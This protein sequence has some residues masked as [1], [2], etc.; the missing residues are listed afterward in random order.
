LLEAAKTGIA[1]FAQALFRGI[2]DI[3]GHQAYSGIFGYYVGLAALYPAQRNKLILRGFLTA[4]LLHALWNTMG[5]LGR[6]NIGGPT[7][8]LVGQV[9]LVFCSLAFLIACILQARKISPTR[10]S[11]FA[12]NLSL[13][14]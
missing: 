8:M 13:A 6:A 1:V 7:V 10:A 4:I 12:T 2:G 14:K 9:A 11:N 3:A 5:A